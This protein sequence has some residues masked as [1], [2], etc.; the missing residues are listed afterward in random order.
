MI[1]VVT[2]LLLLLLSVDYLLGL[3]TKDKTKHTDVTH[4]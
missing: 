1:M 3:T 4:K 2:L